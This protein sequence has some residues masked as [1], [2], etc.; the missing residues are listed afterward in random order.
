MQ[1]RGRGRNGVCLIFCGLFLVFAHTDVYIISRCV[2]SP[3]CGAALVHYTRTR[4]RIVSSRPVPDR[5]I[6]PRGA[7]R[8]RSLYRRRLPLPG[9]PPDAAPSRLAPPSISLASSCWR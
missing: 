2:Q 6:A 7:E 4:L 3:T 1:G 9:L 8:S 5:S